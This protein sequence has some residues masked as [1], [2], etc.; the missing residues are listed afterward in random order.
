MRRAALP[1]RRDECVGGGFDILRR[2]GEAERQPHRAERGMF[3]NAERAQ[4][5][6]SIDAIIAPANPT[7]TLSW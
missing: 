7:I 3:G 2:G 5:V 1:P 6:G 4:R